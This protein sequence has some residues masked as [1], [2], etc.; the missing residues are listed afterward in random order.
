[1]AAHGRLPCLDSPDLAFGP[2]QGSGC[3]LD[4]AD[5]DFAA[6]LSTLEPSFGR[7]GEHAWTA[8]VVVDFQVV[9]HWLEVGRPHPSEED[10][11]QVSIVQREEVDLSVY[12][13][14]V[15]RR[16]PKIVVG[17]RRVTAAAA[18]HI[19]QVLM[20]AANEAESP[21]CR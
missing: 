5:N 4:G 13:A 20:A 1:M 6:L 17:G 12:P 8:S 14:R 2:L 11:A 10:P 15:T 19:A 16:P 7:I 21:R 3:G 9:E 18:R